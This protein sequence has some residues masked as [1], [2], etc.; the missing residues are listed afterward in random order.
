MPSGDGSVE[1]ATTLERAARATELGAT[2][3]RWGGSTVGSACEGSTAHGVYVGMN[4]DPCSCS[5]SKSCAYRTPQGPTP[6]GRLQTPLH[7]SLSSLSELRL[8]GPRPPGCTHRRCS[9]LVTPASTC[10]HSTSQNLSTTNMS[11]MEQAGRRRRSV[12]KPI[13]GAEGV[14]GLVV[15]PGRS[16]GAA[17]AHGVLRLVHA[18]PGRMHTCQGVVG[19]SRKPSHRLAAHACPP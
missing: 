2:S 9:P 19:P 5:D 15:V 6:L 17:V 18:R 3:S 7:E 12:A 10:M 4:T 11:K 16:I 13:L 1:F 14:G 8:H